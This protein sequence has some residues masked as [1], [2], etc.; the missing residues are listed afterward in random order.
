VKPHS[1][2]DEGIVL[3]RKIFSEADRILVIF[4]RYHGKVDVL[5]KGV[6]KVTSRK[7]GHIESFSYIKFSVSEGKGMNLITETETLDNF[8]NIRHDL[9][10]ISVAYF[11]LETVT[12]LTRES[13]SH[14]EAFDILLEY[15]KKLEISDQ[16][17][18][19]RDK[20]TS[21][22]LVTLG[23]WPD[24]QKIDNPDK[25]LEEIIERK[26]STIRVGKKL[27]I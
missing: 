27:L 21:E 14:G 20:F 15:L 7:R 11:F 3:S 22:I 23:F 4:S 16:T 25:V 8:S 13:E 2:K 24:G 10:K 6:R 19:L 9:K 18:E 17:K 12:R 1:Y 5:A 26:M